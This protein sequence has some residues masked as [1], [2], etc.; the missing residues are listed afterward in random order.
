M[1]HAGEVTMPTALGRWSDLVSAKVGVIREVAPQGRGSDEPVPPYLYT[2]TLSHFDFRNADRTERIA[3]GKGLTETDAIASAIA[4]AS[5]RYCAGQWDPDRTAIAPIEAAGPSPIAPS[6]LVLYDEAQYRSD[7]WRCVPW[8]REQ[9]VAWIEAIELANRNPVAVPAS[10][11]YLVTPP[12]RLED[13]FVPA[14]SNGL[15]AGPSIDAAVLAGIC[16]LIERDAL[17]ITWMNRLPAREIDVEGSATAAAA[18]ARHYRRR[19]ID[20]RAFLL[21]TDLPAAVVMAIA[22][23]DREGRPGQVIG[24]GCHPSPR[25]ALTKAVFELCQGRP[26][27]SKRFVDKPPRGRLNTYADVKT[28]DD[29]SA[30]ASLPERRGEFAFLGLAGPRVALGDL[31]DP[32]TGDAARDLDVCVRAL[33]ALGSRVAYVDL[34]LPDIATFGLHVVRTLATALQPVHFG[35]GTERLGGRRLFDVPHRLGLRDR[36][37][38]IADL[39]PCPHPLA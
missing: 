11:V 8:R 3:A 34:T 30:F 17:L 22:F 2:A 27:E 14:T 10:L 36:P 9:D 28:L 37:S 25:I 7:G 31:P 20:L 6:D 23:E 15:A 18:I 29:H 4:E 19:Q 32:S 35:H 33:H 12:P 5:E 13:F 16:E 39:N 24:M 26:A 38:T 21:P 1:L